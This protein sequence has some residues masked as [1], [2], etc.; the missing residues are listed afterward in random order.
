MHYIGF[1]QY[2]AFQ[3]VDYNFLGI[4]FLGLNI[5][6]YKKGIKCT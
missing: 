2:D 6:I 4:C 5:C 3:V 1:D